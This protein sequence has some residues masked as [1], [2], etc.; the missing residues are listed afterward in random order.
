MVVFNRSAALN[1]G[2]RNTA[3]VNVTGDNFFAENITF[4]NDF[5]I[6]QDPNI[7]G[8]QAVA[9]RVTGD[10]AVFHNVRLLALQDTL[11]AAS[12]GCTG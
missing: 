5:K 8:S 1:G 12:K 9:L 11:L 4:Q 10:R 6:M 7:T 3:T 2:T